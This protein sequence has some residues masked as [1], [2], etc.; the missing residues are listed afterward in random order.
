MS[1]LK[2]SVWQI[3]NPLPLIIKLLPYI[4]MRVRILNKHQYGTPCGVLL[5]VPLSSCQMLL[6]DFLSTID[7]CCCDK[8]TL[9]QLKCSHYYFV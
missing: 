2:S 4:S 3:V 8:T 5:P 6:E 9:D 1:A 7:L